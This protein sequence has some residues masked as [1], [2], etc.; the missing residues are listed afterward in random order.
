MVSAV[1]CALTEFDSDDQ[2]QL[3]VNGYAV[4]TLNMA[5]IFPS[6]FPDAI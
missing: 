6:R 2:V 4:P 1:V 5:P 3:L